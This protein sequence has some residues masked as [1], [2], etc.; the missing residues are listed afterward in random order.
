MLSA[1]HVAQVISE[2]VETG[3]PTS[4]QLEEKHKLDYFHCCGG[5]AI[6]LHGEREANAL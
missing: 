5:R 3:T 4:I 2:Q 6:A 1:W